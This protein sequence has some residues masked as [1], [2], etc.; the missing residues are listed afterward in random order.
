MVPVDELRRAPRILQAPRHL[1]G[2]PQ[3]LRRGQPPLALQPP[4]EVFALDQFHGDVVHPVGFPGGIH[5]HQIR[6]AQAGRHPRLALKPRDGLRVLDQVRGEHFQRDRP[7]ER[8]LPRPID[9]P[10]PA[11]PE[12]F[13]HLEVPDD[14]AQRP[15]G[16]RQEQPATGRRRHQLRRLFGRELLV[17]ILGVFRHG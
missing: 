16:R 3:R 15:G 14:L 8:Q 2:D 5:A 17:W 4:P 12:L 1:P 11:R 13:Q 9:R 6:L 7:V 10:H